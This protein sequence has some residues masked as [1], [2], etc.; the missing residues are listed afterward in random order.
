[1]YAGRIVEYGPAA[2]VLKQPRHP[3]TAGSAR[4]DAAQGAARRATADHSRHGATARCARCWMQFCRP[5]PARVRPLPQRA[6]QPRRDRAGPSRGVLE[7]RAMSG[8][9]APLLEAEGLVK[10]FPARDGGGRV[11]AVSGVSLKLWPGETL[12]IVGE[13]GSG[14]STLARL[15]LRLIEA[16]EG[17]IQ[18]DGQGAAPNSMRGLCEPRAATCR[19]S[20]RIPMHRSIRA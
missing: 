16:D 5:L 10:A 6:A 20:S 8:S 18:F 17:S 12:G 19:S 7:P 9:P 13:S 15:L 3:Y 11:K 14:K 4:I 2:D 1:M